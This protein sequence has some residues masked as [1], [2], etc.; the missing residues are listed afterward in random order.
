MKAKHA[1]SKRLVC[2][3]EG[4][5]RAMM[6]GVQCDMDDKRK[7]EHADEHFTSKWSDQVSAGTLAYCLRRKVAIMC[8]HP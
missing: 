7:R 6:C 4:M 2:V 3:D 1:K 5:T 8:Q